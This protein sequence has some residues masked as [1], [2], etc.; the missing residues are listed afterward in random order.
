MTPSLPGDEHRALHRIRPRHGG[1]RLDSQLPA[2]ED[3]E[4]PD[5]AQQRGRGGG[6]HHPAPRVSGGLQGEVSGRPQ[7]SRPPQAGGAGHQAREAA[8]EGKE[9]IA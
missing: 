3:P 6:G 8:G 7:E 4:Q 1:R 9:R 2:R 5:P